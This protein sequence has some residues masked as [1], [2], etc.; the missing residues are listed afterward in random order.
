MEAERK[1]WAIAEETLLSLRHQV[2][3]SNRAEAAKAQ[4]L[5]LD[6]TVLRRLSVRE[7]HD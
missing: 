3:A 7:S 6:E 2:D 1:K 5:L 4:Q